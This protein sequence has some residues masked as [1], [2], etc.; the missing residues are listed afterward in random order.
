MA[1]VAWRRGQLGYALIGE[2]GAVDLEALGQQLYSG[3]VPTTVT[4]NDTGDNAHRT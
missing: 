3:Q 4:G 2:H 1:V